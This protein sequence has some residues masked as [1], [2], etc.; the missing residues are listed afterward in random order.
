M[1]VLLQLSCADLWLR[2]NHTHSLMRT[3]Q[4]QLLVNNCP[5][6]VRKTFNARMEA[7]QSETVFQAHSCIGWEK[8]LPSANTIARPSHGRSLKDIAA[9]KWYCKLK[10]SRWVYS[11]LVVKGLKYLWP[12]SRNIYP[13]ACSSIHSPIDKCITIHCRCKSFR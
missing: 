1:Q 11:S 9:W 4:S 8:R 10:V 3:Q 13:P 7:L 2:S 6:R 12:C 5:S